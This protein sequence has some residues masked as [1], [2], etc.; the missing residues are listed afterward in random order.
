MKITVLIPCHN[1]ELTIKNC[2]LSVL[3]QSRKPDQTIVVNDG[4]SD[5]TQK[6]LRKFGS[7]IRVVNLSKKTGNKSIAQEKGLKYVNGDILI[8]TD[9]DTVLDRDFIKNILKEFKNPKV[10]ASAGYVKSIKQNWLT[11]VRQIDYLISQEIHKKAQSLVDALYVIPGCAAA[12]RT[13]LFKKH[14]PFDHDTLTEDLDFTYKFHKKGLKVT[15]CSEAIV[16][17]QDP[18]RFNDYVMQLRRWHGG[19][20]QNLVKHYDV[21]NRP[22]NALQ[23]SLTYLEGV[24]FPLLLALALILNFKVFI[25]FSLTYLVTVSIFALIGALRDKRWDLLLFIIPYFFASF[26][27]YAIFIEQFIHEA[28]LLK[29]NLKWFKA[30]RKVVYV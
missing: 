14:I 29:G 9:G 19:N 17:T 13:K 1:E 24:T 11:G 23:L 25:Y 27:N 30:K 7:E 21:L 22:S 10:A 4:S 5:K 6:I 20:W 2:I 18:S 28:V 12:Y 16:Y 15:F 3:S 8:T 26:V